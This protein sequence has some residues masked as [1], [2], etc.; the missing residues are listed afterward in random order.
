MKYR[1]LGQSGID[2]SAVALGAWAIGGWMWGGTDEKDAIQ[3]IQSAPDAGV[4]LIDTAPIYGFGTSENI[5]GKAIKGNRD[6]YVIATKCGMVCNTHEGDFKF[7]STVAGPDQNGHIHV[8]VLQRPDSI[9]QE[10]DESLRRLGTDYID[11]YQTHWQDPTTAIHETMACL[12]DLKKEGKIRAIGVS[13]CSGD[14]MDAYRELGPVDSDQEKFNMLDR[15]IEDD[16]LPYC[17]EN[18]I[19]ILAYC[20]MAQGLVTGKMPPEREFAEG[21]LRRANP[22]F[23]VD[24]RE[25]VA[26]MLDAYK[27]VADKHNATLAQLAIAWTIHQPG[28]THALCGA[29]NIDQVKEN[30]AAADIDLSEDDLKVMNEAIEAHRGEIQ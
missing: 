19:A 6:K 16:Q 4:N 10:V 1:A 24:N 9:R 21:D 30:A 27:S 28:L 18:N 23:S 11:L 3:A 29:R 17:R 15:A 7:S 25:R 14:Q 5:V 20:P 12:L 2:A 22:R 13:N 8:Y 26:K